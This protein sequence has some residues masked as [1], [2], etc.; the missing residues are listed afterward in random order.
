MCRWRGPSVNSTTCAERFALYGMA[1]E[2]AVEWGILPWPEGEAL[3]AAAEGFWLW[4]E[5]RGV[6][7]TED[8]QILQAVRAPGMD[9]CPT[10]TIL[11]A[12]AQS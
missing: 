6:G 11:A 3:N 2:L 1:V 8:R 4:R 7:M 9:T 10:E 12:P 5:A